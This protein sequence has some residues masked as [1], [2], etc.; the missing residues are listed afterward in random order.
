MSEIKYDLFLCY[1]GGEGGILAASIYN[2]ICLHSQ[3]K[4]NPFFAPKCIKKGDNFKTECLFTAGKVPLMILLL[5]K[6][7]FAGCF[8][9]DD[10][11]YGEIK[12]AMANE[13]TYFLPIVMSG[14]DFKS[15]D[16]SKLF[17]EAEIDRI[18]HVSAL[19]FNDVYSF[20][21]YDMLLP[22]L[23]D[24]IGNIDVTDINESIKSKL[25][26]KA[27]K[28]QHIADP[29]KIGYFSQQNVSEIK[30]L[31]AQQ[32]LLLQFDNDVYDKYLK[33]KSG[34]KVL[35][36]G[37]SNGKALM[38]RLGD[39]EEVQTIIGVE[40]DEASVQKAKEVYAG[41]KAKFYVVD[42]ESE[43]FDEKMEEIMV[44]NDIDKFDWINV[45]AVVSHLKS[46]Y[47]VFKALK[48][49]CKKGG[50]FFVR[51]IDDGINVA[52]P[53]KENRFKRAFNI[54][55]KCDTVGYRYSGRELFS[56]FA[57]LNFT[58]INLEKFGLNN[59]KMDY[60]DKSAFFDVIF[61]FIKNGLKNA[62]KNHPENEELA[63]E[64]AWFTEN[65]DELEE[66]FLARETFV[67]F[68]FLTYVAI[69]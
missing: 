29:N 49:I 52:Y 28:R 13:S 38:A 16:L 5:S 15:Q 34:L 2:E 37:C 20:S 25:E 44:E 4:I 10:I 27:V 7:F 62:V 8:E 35:D 6:D 26:D 22:I 41:T 54:L 61:G 45:L 66:Q 47:K 48:K 12:S 1:R 67:N 17:D 63:V 68:G 33:G 11:V 69:V 9:E 31:N 46:P 42:L 3:G 60:D 23:R 30:R 21:A 55:S 43:D 64:Q 65:L 36:I 51:N 58:E 32:Q 59:I 57:T 50:I 14:F 56:I 39:R 53:D 18:K 24:K 19:Q 40:F